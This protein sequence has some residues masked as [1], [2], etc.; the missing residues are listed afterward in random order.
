[1][2]M[3]APL[4]ST[5]ELVTLNVPFDPLLKPIAK[6]VPSSKRSFAPKSM[7]KLPVPLRPMAIPLD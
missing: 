7:V 5:V 2:A 4:A 1:M 3:T 6:L